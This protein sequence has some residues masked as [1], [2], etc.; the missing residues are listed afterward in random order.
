MR[1]LLKRRKVLFPTC[2]WSMHSP[3]QPVILS[4]HHDTYNFDYPQFFC[5]NN[6]E[7]SVLHTWTLELLLLEINI[8]PFDYHIPW[9]QSMYT[10]L[11][12]FNSYL[13]QQTHQSKLPSNFLGDS[14]A[15]LFNIFQNGH[16]FDPHRLLMAN[17]YTYSPL[18]CHRILSRTYQ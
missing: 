9:G 10:S 11:S 14:H 2:G 4:R 13:L 1:M 8:T 7:K 3:I 18:H 5:T 17:I 6:D 12:Y 15:H 16:W